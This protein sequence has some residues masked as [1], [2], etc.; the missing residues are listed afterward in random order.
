MCSCA[1]ALDR[2]SRKRGRKERA[3]LACQ[4]FTLRE[5][6]AA[7]F[8]FN[9]VDALLR[10]ILCVARRTNVLYTKCA[11]LYNLHGGAFFGAFRSD[12]VNA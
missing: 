10:F 11:K 9:A 7:F 6:F 2:F 1:R 5:M 3:R 8:F 12:G 4:F